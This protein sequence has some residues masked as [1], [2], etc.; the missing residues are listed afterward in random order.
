M[1]VALPFSAP[2][3]FSW[4]LR[5]TCSSGA[6]RHAGMLWLRI[7]I[8]FRLPR[9]AEPPNQQPAWSTLFT[10]SKFAR[11]WSEFTEK[12]AEAF[13]TAP[14]GCIHNHKWPSW[15]PAISEGRIRVGRALDLADF[16]VCKDMIGPWQQSSV[17]SGLFCQ[18]LGTLDH[19]WTCIT[20]VIIRFWVNNSA[21]LP[22]DEGLSFL[23]SPR[24][25]L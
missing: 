22:L 9:T 23:F 13:P 2:Q 10:G 1:A 25:N 14:L 15:C 8:K 19:L 18:M 12:T 24:Q 7:V 6:W 17:N 20:F 3:Q 21:A 4:V 16:S 5:V 11:C